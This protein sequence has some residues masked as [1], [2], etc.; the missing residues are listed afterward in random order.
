MYLLTQELLSTFSSQFLVRSTSQPDTFLFVFVQNC[1]SSI[2]VAGCLANSAAHTANKHQKA[3]CL[4]W[5]I[6]KEIVGVSIS[7]V[8]FFISP[9]TGTP[10]TATLSM[11]V[12]LPSKIPGSKVMPHHFSLLQLF[13]RCCYAEISY[14]CNADRQFL[15]QTDM[16]VVVPL[17]RSYAHPT[18]A[19]SLIFAMICNNEKEWEIRQVAAPSKIVDDKPPHAAVLLELQADQSSSFSRNPNEG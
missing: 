4:L 15:R 2:I 14:I 9:L 12:I 18:L 7:K 10:H 3:F 5:I 1:F 17:C 6:T 16:T 8:V 13:H 11:S 19:E